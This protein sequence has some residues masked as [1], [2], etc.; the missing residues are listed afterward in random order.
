[1]PL[2]TFIG[3]MKGGDWG[4]LDSCFLDEREGE[5]ERKGERERDRR[6]WDPVHFEQGELAEKWEKGT[7]KQA[8]GRVGAGEAA[9]QEVEG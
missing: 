5:E 1:M 2:S 4:S 3:A 8:C 6:A 7:S 9:G